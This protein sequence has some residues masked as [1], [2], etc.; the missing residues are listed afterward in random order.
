MRVA[1]EV[2]LLG[3]APFCP[4]HNYHFQLQLRGEEKLDVRHYYESTLAWLRAAD[5]VLV[6]PGWQTS[7][8]TKK[9][10]KEA[11]R[12]KIPIVY[13]ERHKSWKHVTAE[14]PFKKAKR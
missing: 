6:L 4:W 8:G 13:I 7:K 12:L 2:L 14:S 10:I 5:E 9:E 3:Y 1:T 11:K